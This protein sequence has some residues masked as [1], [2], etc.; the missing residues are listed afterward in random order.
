M[1]IDTV[2]SIKDMKR[3]SHEIIHEKLEQ[4][5]IE[6]KVFPLTFVEYYNNYVFSQKN[7]LSERLPIQPSH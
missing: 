6:L 4:A 5:G 3:I 1:T 2:L 7:A